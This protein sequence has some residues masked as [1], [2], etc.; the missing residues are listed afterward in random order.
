MGCNALSAAVSIDQVPLCVIQGDSAKLIRPEG[1]AFSPTG[2]CV[3]VAD[4]SGNSIAAYK[5]INEYI[6]DSTPCW[7]LQDNDLLN[8][9]HE[10]VFSSCGQYI[11]VACRNAHAVVLFQRDPAREC[12]FLE[13]PHFRIQKDLSTHFPTSIAFSSDG[14]QL[15]ICDSIPRGEGITF[16]KQIE[17]QPY[18]FS[19]ESFNKITALEMKLHKLQPPQSISLSP[20]GKDLAVCHWSFRTK[21][22]R[23]AVI[24][25]HDELGQFNLKSATRIPCDP[26]KM[27]TIKFHPSNNFLMVTVIPYGIHFYEK[28]PLD[29]NYHLTLKMPIH[30][31][32]VENEVVKGCA[33]SASG[34]CLAVT[35]PEPSI[36]FFSLTYEV[37]YE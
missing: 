11:A 36:Q 22:G 29:Q 33:F 17:N 28:D 37:S 35:T 27:H 31:T 12:A 4:S 6:Y 10:V 30:T 26:G 7:H 13:T 14:K 16:Y 2:D 9:A 3:V 18:L 32:P 1:V 8:F 19:T 15:A 21:R 34:D 20:D 5:R 25:Y 24:V 23:S